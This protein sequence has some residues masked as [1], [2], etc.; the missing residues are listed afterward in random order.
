M[1]RLMER[2]ELEARPHG[3]RSSFRTWCAEATDTPREIAEM[4]LAHSIGGKVELSYRRTDYIDKRRVL[5]ERWA[6]HVSGKTANSQ[7]VVQL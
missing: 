6:K 5:M 3:F 1:S 2:F 7:N 4:A